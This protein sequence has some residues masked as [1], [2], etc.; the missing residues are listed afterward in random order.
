MIENDMIE[1]YFLFLNLGTTKMM[2]TT[3]RFKK[4]SYRAL[5]MLSIE[6][7]TYTSASFITYFYKINWFVLKAIVFWQH[8]Q[9]CSH[10]SV[11]RSRLTLLENRSVYLHNYSKIVSIYHLSKTVRGIQH[12]LTFLIVISVLQTEAVQRKSRKELSK[13]LLCLF[14][15]Q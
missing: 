13:L 9:N 6:C 2:C 10:F 5:K 7:I 1:K 4:K 3:Y 14:V 15:S 12:F 11:V 8:T